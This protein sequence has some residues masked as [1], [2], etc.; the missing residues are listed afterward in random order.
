MNSIYNRLYSIYK[1]HRS[2]NLF[3]HLATAKLY[4]PS[5]LTI[6]L[7][8]L[9][10]RRYPVSSNSINCE[11]AIRW[12]FN[13]QDATKI[14]GVS[15][16]YSY[17]SGWKWAYPE[18]SGYIIPT[19]FDFAEYYDSS[20]IASECRTRAARIADWLVE[21]QLQNGGYPWCYVPSRHLTV[22]EAI[23]PCAAAH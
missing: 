8:D 19:L 16:C 6:L 3:Y 9:I 21:I 5:H 13:A 10:D 20:P 12:L 17:S 23:P 11:E 14:G 7:S 4:K 18:T 2:V 1:N 22:A 15:A